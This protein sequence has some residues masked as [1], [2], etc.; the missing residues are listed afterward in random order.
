MDQQNDIGLI[1]LAVMGQNSFSTWPTTVSRSACLIA[2]LARS[3]NFSPVPPRGSRFAAIIRYAELIA[4]LKPPRKIMM[5]V[6]AGPAV[7][8]LSASLSR[9]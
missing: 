5:M 4:G 1:G 8:E 7:D 9:T 2:R 3:T 6:K